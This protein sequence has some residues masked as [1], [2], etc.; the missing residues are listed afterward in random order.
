MSSIKQEKIIRKR[1]GEIPIL[2][3]IA[4]RLKFKEILTRYIKPHKNEKISAV[5]SILLLVFNIACGRQ[6][7]YE[8]DEWVNKLDIRL[9]GFD[10]TLPVDVFNDDRFARVL[11]KV[12]NADNGDRYCS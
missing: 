5:D 1:V 8:I 12:F 11:D 4:D 7:L 10:H 9:F 6:P 3:T 2:Q